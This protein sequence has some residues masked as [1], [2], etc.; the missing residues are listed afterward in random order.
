M[1][2]A[3]EGGLASHAIDHA[4]DCRHWHSAGVGVKLMRSLESTSVV[5]VRKSENHHKKISLV[6]EPSSEQGAAV[7]VVAR[8]GVHGDSVGRDYEA[9]NVNLGVALHKACRGRMTAEQLGRA[10]AEVDATARRVI[11]APWEDPALSAGGSSLFDPT[12]GGGGI[13]LK[14]GETRSFRPGDTVMCQHRGASANTHWYGRL[15]YRGLGALETYRLDLSANRLTGACGPWILLPS[16]PSSLRRRDQLSRSVPELARSIPRQQSRATW[17]KLNPD[18]IFGNYRRFQSYSLAHDH[19]IGGHVTDTVGNMCFDLR[20]REL[21][22]TASYHKNLK[23]LTIVQL[24]RM[25]DRIK[26]DSVGKKWYEMSLEVASWSKRRIEEGQ[27]IALAVEMHKEESNRRIEGL[28]RRAEIEKEEAEDAVER[29]NKER[30]EY[31]KALEKLEEEKNKFIE[32]T[33]EAEADGAVNDEESKLLQ[34]ELLDVQIAEARLKKEQ[35]EFEEWEARALKEIQEYEDMKHRCDLEIQRQTQ[36]LH[37][38]HAVAHEASLI[39]YNA[40]YLQYSVLARLHTYRPRHGTP[41]F[42]AEHMFDNLNIVESKNAAEDVL[43]EVE[44]VHHFHV[45]KKLQH[46][47]VYREDFVGYCGQW[48]NG[49]P[50]GHGS[51]RHDSMHLEYAGQFSDDLWDGWG[52]LATFENESV[53]VGEYRVKCTVLP[54]ICFCWFA[55]YAG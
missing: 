34:K 36:W 30:A 4:A 15:G 52:M 1:E 44:T 10:C 39:K 22:P 35:D 29:V 45:T 24:S 18:H 43:V 25:W 55:S 21:K 26:K 27:R 9:P 47:C 14:R 46:A 38:A 17:D 11:K 28:L 33:A 13:F 49:R 31:L 3:Q 5:G 32:M 19:H 53:Y 12:L 40:D 20:E 50:E 16:T 8:L 7:R 48:C 41:E 54:C 42:E 23:H 2:A 51:E 6:T 37:E